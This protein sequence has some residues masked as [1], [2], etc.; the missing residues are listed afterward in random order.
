MHVTAAVDVPLGILGQQHA[1]AHRARSAVN[2][3]ANALEGVAGG[4]NLACF[5]LRIGRGEHLE[6]REGL[7]R[8][9]VATDILQHGLGFAMH[10]DDDRILPLRQA[11][12]DLRRM[13][14][15]MA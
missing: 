8:L 11:A 4:T 3:C 10:R 7:L 13:R 2:A 15:E 6:K 1:Q 9:L 5:N 12:N 14:L